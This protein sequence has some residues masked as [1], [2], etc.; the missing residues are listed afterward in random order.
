M[1]I[2]YVGQN[3]VLF[4]NYA[5]SAGKSA[6]KKN[7]SF[8]A[9]DAKPLRNKRALTRGHKGHEGISALS[10]FDFKSGGPSVVVKEETRTRPYSF[11]RG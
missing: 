4:H 6:A 9:K 7:K 5:S 10:T 8:T 2:S 1:K 11:P 3:P